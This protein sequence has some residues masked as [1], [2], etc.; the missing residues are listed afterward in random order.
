MMHDFK[1][2]ILETVNSNFLRVSV[3]EKAPYDSDTF[4]RRK[5]YILFY[6]WQLPECLQYSNG[7]FV[8]SSLIP[9]ANTN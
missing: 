9:T 8:K 4:L 3:C 5:K 6:G 2:N 1:Q 7:P